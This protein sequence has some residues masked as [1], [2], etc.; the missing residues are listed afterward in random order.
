[1]TMSRCQQCGHLHTLMWSRR[2]CWQCLEHEP[3]AEPVPA[4]ILAKIREGE[5]CLRCVQVESEDRFELLFVRAES[6]IDALKL[7][8]VTWP[9]A[10][11]MWARPVDD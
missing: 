10:T 9:G 11:N 2:L 3:P 6:N 8:A 1:M 4:V 7:G 5:M